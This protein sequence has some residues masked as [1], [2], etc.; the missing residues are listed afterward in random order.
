M[1]KVDWIRYIVQNNPEGAN[2]VLQNF[3]YNY[4]TNYEDLEDAVRFLQIQHGDK[5]TLELLKVHPDRDILTGVSSLNT[6]FSNATGDENNT[7]N[8]KTPINQNP[9]N[10]AQP[11][12]ISSSNSGFDS[13]LQNTLLIIVAFWLIKEI[14]SK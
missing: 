8:N 11:I 9:Y 10:Q 13:L 6:I 1:E 2:S 12:I 7:E 4:E 3:G 14:I 5:A